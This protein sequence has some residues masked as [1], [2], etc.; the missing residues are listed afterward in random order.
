MKTLL[1]NGTLGLLL[2]ILAGIANADSLRPVPG[3]FSVVFLGADPSTGELIAEGPKTGPLS[4]HLA[5]RSLITQQTGVALHF[6]AHWTLTTPSGETISGEN[7][8]VL[9]TASLHFREHGV[10]VDASGSLTE[11]IGNFI[12]IEG[13]FSDLNFVPGVTQITGKATIVPSQASQAAVGP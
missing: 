12:V 2:V 11:R 1:I 6:S 3:E 4:G 9:S 5:I 13:Q 8:G 7:S 10:I